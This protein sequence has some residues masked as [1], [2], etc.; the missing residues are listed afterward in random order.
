MRKLLIGLTVL[1]ILLVVAD[2]VAVKIAENRIGSQIEAAY[3]L[4]SRPTVSIQGF[5]FLTQVITG[6][7]PEVDVSTPQAQAGAA[8]LD[9]LRV[10]FTDVHAALS[11]ML[12]SGQKSVTAGHA[13]GWATLP[14]AEIEQHLPRGM[15]L[16]PHGNDLKVSGM[17][18]VGALRVPV[19]G[20]VALAV[21]SAGVAVRPLSLTTAGGVGVPAAVALP[22]GVVVPIAA[23][24]L[25][26]HLRSVRVTPGG[27]RVGA[28]ASNVHF[29][30]T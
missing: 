2:R 13:D 10:R 26:L 9:G 21:T 8:T 24:P 22:L 7:Y 30:R 15:R 5:P 14:F 18:Q 29:A 4:S 19:S 6:D 12:G 20:T 17:L 1:V 11:Q 25:H 3:G 23:L 28:S 16:K 27:V